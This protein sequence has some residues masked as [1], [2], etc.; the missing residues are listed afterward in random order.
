MMISFLL[1]IY[2]YPIHPCGGGG[3]GMLLSAYTIMQI[4]NILPLK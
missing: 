4:L 1:E 2:T 3:A